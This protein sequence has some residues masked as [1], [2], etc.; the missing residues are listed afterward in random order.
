MSASIM[1][2]F[3]AVGVIMLQYVIFPFFILYSWNSVP[4]GAS[5]AEMPFPLRDL[6]FWFWDLMG[7]DF[8]NSFILFAA[9][10]I[11]RAWQIRLW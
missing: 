2:R 8:S 6:G 5:T 11:S 4:L 1:L 10:K 9:S 3:C 7:G